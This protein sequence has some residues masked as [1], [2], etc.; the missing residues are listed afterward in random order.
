MKVQ[1][2]LSHPSTVKWTV[3]SLAFRKIR[4]NETSMDG[5][6]TIEWD[7]QDKDGNLV[8]NGLYYLRVQVGD[9]KTTDKI[10]KV[11]ILR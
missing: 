1:V 3:Y 7:L 6:G 8:S 2:G 11:L 5:T 4:G 10:F 9:D